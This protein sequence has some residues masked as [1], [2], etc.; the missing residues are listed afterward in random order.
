V[1]KNYPIAKR[2]QGFERKMSLGQSLFKKKTGA[3]RLALARSFLINKK[4]LK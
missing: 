4:N 3:G 1:H 2:L